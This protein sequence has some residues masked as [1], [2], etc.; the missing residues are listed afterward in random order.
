MSCDGSLMASRDTC[1][2]SIR[3]KA[4]KVIKNGLKSTLIAEITRIKVTK[5][6][7][8][9]PPLFEMLHIAVLAVFDRPNPFL[10]R[11][12]LHLTCCQTHLLDSGAL[13]FNS[14]ARCSVT[15][16]G[17]RETS[18]GLGPAWVWDTMF[19]FSAM[20]LPYY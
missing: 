4:T 10:L 2:F 16:A 1:N 14:A 6:G 11:E 8:P 9:L 20:L 12:W 3:V 13:R 18:R 7:N 17:Y 15:I 5:K 19:G